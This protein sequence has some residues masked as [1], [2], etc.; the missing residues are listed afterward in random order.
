MFATAKAFE[1][2]LSLLSPIS[3]PTFVLA[4]TVAVCAVAMA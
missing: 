2:V 3:S 1:M 4:E